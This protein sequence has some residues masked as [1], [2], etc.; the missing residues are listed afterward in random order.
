[1][2]YGFPVIGTLREM[3][4]FDRITLVGYLKSIVKVAVD[5]QDILKELFLQN[6]SD[7]D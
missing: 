7:V 4:N 2:L 1:M 6:R 3:G 5:Q